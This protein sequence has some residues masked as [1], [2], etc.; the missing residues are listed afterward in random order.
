MTMSSTFDRV[1]RLIAELGEIDPAD[2]SLRGLFIYEQAAVL[3][4][5]TNVLGLQVSNYAVQT[6]GERSF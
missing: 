2:V 4:P 5:A 6:I 1:R 3:N